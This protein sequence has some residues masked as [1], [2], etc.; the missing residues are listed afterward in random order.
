[1]DENLRIRRGLMARLRSIMRACGMTQVQA[2]RHFG[3]SQSRISHLANDQ[4]DRFR[5]DTLIGMLAHAGIRVQVT[6]SVDDSAATLLAIHRAPPDAGQK[7]GARR[8][9]A[10]STRKAPLPDVP[11]SKS[12]SGGRQECPLPIDPS[13]R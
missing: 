7:R 3:V 12:D 1:M 11:R 2:G 10:R 5:T 13:H 8:P 4:V 6:F 9:G